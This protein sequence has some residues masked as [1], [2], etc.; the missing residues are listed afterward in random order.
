MERATNLITASALL[1]PPRGDLGDAHVMHR[2]AGRAFKGVQNL[3]A[4]EVSREL[5]GSKPER[6]EA[7]AGTGNVDDRQ[8][9]AAGNDA[10]GN[11]ARL[12]GAK[13]SRCR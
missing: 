8:N 2:V 6:G 9:D 1:Y 3:K 5:S 7:F 4:L 11:D 10:A 13:R 12:A